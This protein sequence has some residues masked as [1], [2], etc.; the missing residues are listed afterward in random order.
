MVATGQYFFFLL[1]MPARTHISN[2]EDVYIYIVT[3]LDNVRASLFP[4][5]LLEPIILSIE[6]W[7]LNIQDTFTHTQLVD[8]YRGFFLRFNHI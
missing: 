3:T 4:R 1:V 7:C 8:F 5:L 2:M 6:S